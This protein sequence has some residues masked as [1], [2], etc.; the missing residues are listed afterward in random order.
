M[1]GG[2]G[3]DRLEGGGGADILDGDAFLHVDLTRDANGNIFAGSQIIREIRY[4]DTTAADAN[5]V[6]TAVYNDNA[7]NYTLTVQV[8]DGNG[9]FG[10]TIVQAL[11]AATIAGLADG[12]IRLGTDTQGFA[13]LAH[14]TGGAVLVPAATPLRVDDGIDSLRNIERL[15]FADQLVDISGGRNHTP[16][17]A[18]TI[19]DPNPRDPTGVPAVGDILTATSTL[20]DADF[21]GGIITHPITYQWQDQDLVRGEWLNITG[22]DSIGA[23]ANFVPTDF[24]QGVAIR[25]KATYID[26]HGYQ[27]TVFSD[28]LAAG[29][30]L[31]A[32]PAKNTGPT[33]QQRVV[34]FVSSTTAYVGET[35]NIFIPVQNKFVDDH[36]ASTALTYKAA[37]VDAAGVAHDITGAAF[38]GLQFTVQTDNTGA[39]IGA[40]ITGTIPAGLNGPITVRMSVSDDGDF[41]LRPANVPITVLTTTTDFKIN[42]VNATGPA[43][44]AETPAAPLAADPSRGPGVHFDRVDLDF[45]LQQIKMAEANQP[46]ISAHLAFGLRTVSGEDN[47]AVG[48]QGTFGES[49]QAFPRL[50]TPVLGLAG[51][52]P[53]GFFGPG[54]PAA[55]T[56]YAQTS[57]FVFDSDPRLI[58]NLIADQSANNPAA[59]AAALSQ[60]TV[61]P[62]VQDPN[63]VAA[64]DGLD[65]TGPVKLPSPNV[66]PDGGISA[67]FNTWFTLFGQFFDHGLDLVNKGGN[68]QVIIPLLPD[69]PLY[70]AGS[71]TNFMV[72]SR[73]TLIERSAGADGIIGTADDVY[74]HETTNAITPPVDLSQVFSSHPSHQVFLREYITGA[75]GAIHST[76]RMLTHVNADGSLHLPNWADI[77][78][79]ALTELGLKLSDPDVAS[80][81]LVQADEYGNVVRGPNGFAMVTYQVL[82]SVNGVTTVFR[83]GSIEGKAGGLNLD[84]L[85]NELNNDGIATDAVPV[86]TATV[87]YSVQYVGAGVAFI[88]DMARAANPYDDFGHLKAS[89]DGALLNA[90]FIAGDGRVNEN[91]GLTSIHDIFLREVNRMADQTKALIQQILDD[92]DTST[93][94]EWVLSG[95]DVTT[96]TAADVA[97]HRTTHL[98]TDTEWNGERIFQAARFGSETQYQHLV[99]E[100]F[101]RKVAPDIHLSGDT[102][103][104][105][106]PAVFAEFAHTVYRFGHSMLDENLQRFSVHQGAA[107][108]PLNGTPELGQAFLAGG[109]GTSFT[110]TGADAAHTLTNFKFTSADGLQLTDLAFTGADAAHTLTSSQFTAADGVTL[111]DLAFTA[112]DGVTLTDLA[113]T[114][115][116]GVALTDLAFTA[117]DGTLTNFAFTAA[118]GTL[119]NDP[120]TPGDGTVANTTNTANTANAANTANTAN[121]ANAVNPLAGLPILLDANGDQVSPDIALLTAFTNPLAYEAAGKDAA[122]QLALGSIAQVGN[123]IDEFVTGTLRNNLLGA[124]LDLA[125]LNLARGRSEGVPTLNM[126]RNELFSQ[127][128]DHVLKPYD[129]WH[130][131]GQ[132]LKHPE[133]LINFVAAYGTGMTGTAA[134]RRADATLLVTAGENDANHGN[135]TDTIT[136]HTG[137]TITVGE[138][139]NFMHSAGDWA[140]IPLD[141]SYVND[142]RAIHSVEIDPNTGGPVTDALGNPM[143]DPNPPTYSTGSITGLDQVDF[144][145][146]GLAEKHSLHDSMLGST[147]DFVFKLQLENL[148]DGDRLYYLPRIEGMHFSDQ[149][150]NNS[151]AEMI[152]N[153]TGTKHL[154]ASIFLTPEYQIEAGSFYLHNA[155]G[156]LLLDGNGNPSI[157]SAASLPAFTGADG[158]LHPLVEILPDRTVHFLGEDNFFGNTMV[159]G[160]TDGNDRLMAGQADDDTVYGDGGNDTID[161]GG[162]NDNLFGGDGDDVLSNSNSSIGSVFHGDAGNDTIVGSKGDDVI[163]GGDGQDVIYGGQGIDDIVGGTGNDIIYGGEGGEEIQG[164]QGDD[165]IVGGPDGGDV[166][167]GDVGAP[168]GG[169]PLYAGNDVLIGGVGTVMKGFSGDDIMLG[170]GGHLKFDGGLGFDWA[171][172]E[173]ETQS[174]EIDMARREFIADQNPAGGDGFRDIYQLTEGASGS[175]FD[176]VIKGDNKTRVVVARNVMDDPTLIKGLADVGGDVSTTVLGNPTTEG[177]FF[178]SGLPTGAVFTDPAGAKAAGDFGGN[179]LLGG[180]GSDSIGGG[181]GD[182]ILD[183]DAYLHV[184]LLHNANGE[185]GS[186][187]EILREIRYSNAATDIDTAVFSANFADYTIT[188]ADSLGFITVTETAGAIQ[189]GGN[190]GGVGGAFDGTDRIRNFER[191]QFADFTFTIDKVGN[192]YDSSGQLM[193]GANG[194]VDGFIFQPFPD[195]PD[196][197]FPVLPDAV[198]SVFDTFAPLSVG[199]ATPGVNVDGTPE[200]GKAVTL[201]V[202]NA[203]DGVIIGTGAAALADITDLDFSTG[204]GDP[205]VIPTDAFKFQWQYLDIKLGDWVAI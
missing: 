107:G 81:P 142:P 55:A 103:I 120:G 197:N 56:S 31:L 69:D 72:L 53:A 143:L 182:D 57:G 148:Q 190:Q 180:A 114:A 19:D 1:L 173:N 88:N 132:F 20:T 39:V 105:L 36:T 61:M 12:S 50:T 35:V 178:F 21:A 146:G 177:N 93:A 133:S 166:L 44:A 33:A 186:G 179:I 147:F 144:W 26:A 158:L 198:P 98:I 15:Q 52:I 70:H 115:A 5:A 139:W 193:V 85:R 192:L 176:D 168:T 117:A 83:E 204:P 126:V 156:S 91:I 172:F 171:S 48:G 118:D 4:A 30:L 163:T 110:F 49:D 122:G 129:S 184:E 135:S 41:P 152:M 86:D 75:D 8:S 140:N 136:L 92:G 194:A 162:G 141:A 203:G 201:Q 6:D 42:V 54:S 9:G 187:S 138:A 149:I 189:P 71:S 128:G 191:I 131:F 64:T 23:P 67:P 174:V 25:L 153:A 150:E 137:V 145:I 125:A 165:W 113:F 104:H 60:A 73:G 18:L 101:A 24:F 28:P 99:F 7:G 205:G 127:T 77:K 121:A 96:L 47:S 63:K 160:G 202:S 181:S 164:D 200:V 199:V 106:D 130:E 94:Q 188:A 78:A 159:L 89:W 161:G 167:F 170:V 27:E 45:I 46:P 97:A 17:G 169:F 87:H 124:P 111:T 102:N 90:H 62:A 196:A 10:P 22:A 38:N 116:D 11:D 51:P 157:D 3:S 66:T 74:S 82:Q 65:I 112:A 32:D 185:I 2:G 80:V 154:S 151:F 13:T 119:T 183:G 109:Q 123:E 155:D 58:S 76:G 79:N 175:M 134:D 43:P 195:V 34:D 95:V 100:E 108:D 59:L 16:G 84:D 37:I 68:G 14:L 40:N 29:A